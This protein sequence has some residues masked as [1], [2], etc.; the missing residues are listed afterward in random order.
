MGD[1]SSMEYEVPGPHRS[2]KVLFI[3]TLPSDA[4][5]S[6]LPTNSTFK[7]RSTPLGSGNVT[8][9]DKIKNVHT[10]VLISYIQSS[11]PLNVDGYS[12]CPNLNSNN[13]GY[14]PAY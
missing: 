5:I 6:L 12:F 1:P 9:K 14:D 7:Y 11:G 4:P 3:V 2:P 8:V 10:R 13:A